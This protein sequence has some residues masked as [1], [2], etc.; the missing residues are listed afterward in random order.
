MIISLISEEETE[1]CDRNEAMRLLKRLD[2][3]NDDTAVFLAL[4]A[5]VAVNFS[6][7]GQE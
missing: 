3:S 5:K 7:Y 1:F 2:P 6:S 4:D